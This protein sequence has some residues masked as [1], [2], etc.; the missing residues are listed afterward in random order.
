MSSHTQEAFSDG[1]SLLVEKKNNNNSCMDS[2]IAESLECL[3]EFFLQFL[4][5][6][7]LGCSGGGGCQIIEGAAVH[8]G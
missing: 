4:K 5:V 1:L 2:A 3:V 7:N 6:Y 8:G